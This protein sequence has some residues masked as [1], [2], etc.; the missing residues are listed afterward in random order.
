MLEQIIELLGK[1]LETLD[2]RYRAKFNQ[3][4]LNRLL[5]MC[6]NQTDN[7]LLETI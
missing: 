4:V 6:R 3:I 5:S 2:Y 7:R 1:L